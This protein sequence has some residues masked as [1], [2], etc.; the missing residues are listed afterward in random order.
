M[1]WTHQAQLCRITSN[2]HKFRACLLGLAQDSLTL[3]PHPLLKIAG[4]LLVVPLQV[5]AAEELHPLVMQDAFS[6]LHP[7]L[8]SQSVAKHFQLIGGQLQSDIQAHLMLCCCWPCQGQQAGLGT[9]KAC[10]ALLAAPADL[11]LTIY[12]F[13]SRSTG[14]LTFLDIV[15]AAPQGDPGL[16]GQ[17]AACCCASVISTAVGKPLSR[18]CQP[19][20]GTTSTAT[21]CS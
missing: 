19:A 20:N 4:V 12:H 16:R 15:A 18:S 17:P 8:G 21:G 7:M 5:L 10:C 9:A 1:Q 13:T 14:V 6:P 3:G 2:A 11:L